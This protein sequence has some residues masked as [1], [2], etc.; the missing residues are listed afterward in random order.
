MRSTTCKFCHWPEKVAV[1]A[2]A[3]VRKLGQSTA[4]YLRHGR[5]T[6]GF[7]YS[8]QSGHAARVP[9]PPRAQRGE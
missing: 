7:R 2:E 4:V 5:C 6:A 8:G 1:A 9:A 3:A